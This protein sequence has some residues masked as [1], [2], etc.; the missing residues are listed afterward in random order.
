MLLYFI[1]CF[2]GPCAF[3][4]FHC[5]CKRWT[6]V[7]IQ[8]PERYGRL[9]IMSC[10]FSFLDINSALFKH[11]VGSSRVLNGGTFCDVWKRDVSKN[12]EVCRTLRATSYFA[13]G[14][15]AL[16][17]GRNGTKN[18]QQCNERGIGMNAHTNSHTHTQR[19]HNITL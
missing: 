13:G 12:E 9:E 2:S 8:L 14:G 16:K 1:S 7:S 15:G 11:S 18:T 5:I 19:G 17:G 4:L 10:N 6:G 3:P